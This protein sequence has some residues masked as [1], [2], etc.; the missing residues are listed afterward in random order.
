MIPVMFILGLINT[1]KRVKVNLN[2]IKPN[3]F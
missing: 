2:L 1:K 3:E